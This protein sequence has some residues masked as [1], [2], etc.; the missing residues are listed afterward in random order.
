M[1]TRSDDAVQVGVLPAKS[2]HPKAHARLDSVKGTKPRPSTAKKPKLREIRW[3][4]LSLRSWLEILG[5]VAVAFAIYSI[6]FVK[7]TVVEYRPGHQFTVSDPSFFGSAHAAA[8]P[9]PVEGNKITLLHNG[10]GAFPAMLQAIAA[11]EKSV[12]FEAFLFH[13]GEV[14]DKFIK[15]LTERAKAGVEVRV[16]LDGVGSGRDLKSEDVDRFK[17][18]GLKFAYY[19]P[20]RALRVDRLNRRTHRRVLVVDG[21]VAFTGGVG[22]ADEWKGNADAPDHWRE[23]HA[24]LEGPIVAKLQAAFQQ[25]WLAETKEMLSGPSQFPRLEP[26]GP[27]KAQVTSSTE[28]SVAAVPLIQAVAISSA[29]KTICITNPYCTPTDDQVHLLTEAVKRGVD[30]RMLLPGKH[31]D[32]PWTKAAGRGSYGDLLKGGVKIYEYTPTMVHSKTMVIDGMFSMFGTSNLDARSSAINEEID[33]SVLDENFGR[34]MD[35]VF[36]KDLAQAR[37]YKMEDFEKRSMW[38]RFTEWAAAPFRS[39]L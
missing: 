25:H 29:K 19:H 13:S 24:K 26:A 15:A 33:V 28:F 2:G 32:Q 35:A 17:E 6:L 36:A 31:N 5:G 4:R 20:T 39:Q 34:E 22:F 12:N 38:E 14:G 3:G 16:L 21:K 1:F 11:A 37:E 10:D 9:V 23:V 7:R 27:L 18:G 8:D 30:V